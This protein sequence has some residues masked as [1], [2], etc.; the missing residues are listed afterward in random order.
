MAEDSAQRREELIR[1]IRETSQQNVHIL[2]D[3]KY[4]SGYIADRTEEESIP[5][6]SFFKLRC[7]ICACA[8]CGFFILQQTGAN[9]FNI[10]SEKIISE[11]S[12]NTNAES[13]MN[14]ITDWVGIQDP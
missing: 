4:H 13:V 14:Q 5:T 11:L 6:K 2:R 7:I 8:L 10:S 1:S 12:K 3:K 9:L